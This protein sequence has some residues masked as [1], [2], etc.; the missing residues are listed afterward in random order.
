[1]LRM[2]GWSISRAIACILITSSPVA[3]GRTS[4]TVRSWYIGAS[5]WIRLSGTNSVKPPVA[6]WRSRIRSRCAARWRGVSTCPYMIVAVVG[7]PSRWAPVITRTQAAVEMR[8]GEI[9]RRTASSRISA[10][11]P[12]REPTPASFSRARYSSIEQADRTDP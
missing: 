12:G 5:S 2:W 4:G 7:M 6:F 3:P 9:R 11:V 10:E 1:M 8:P